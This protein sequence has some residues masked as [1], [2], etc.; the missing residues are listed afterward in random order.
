MKICDLC[1]QPVKEFEKLKSKYRITGVNE[2]CPECL[3]ELD[4][5]IIKYKHFWDNIKRQTERTW[6]SRV[7]DGIKAKRNISR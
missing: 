5:A 4:E 2:V 7:I 6:L 1:L 3:K